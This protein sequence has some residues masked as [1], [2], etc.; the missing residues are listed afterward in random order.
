MKYR[1][2]QG[3]RV[4]ET[5]EYPTKIAVDRIIRTEWVDLVQGL[6]VM[7]R[8]FCY[9]G[10]VPGPKWFLRFLGILGRKS[11]RGY[12]A[13]DALF[14]LMKNGHLE[15]FWK[16]EADKLMHEI[17]LRDGMAKPAAKVVYRSVVAFGASSI[18]P[19]NRVK[20]QTAP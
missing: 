7:K 5:W 1:K 9:E 19:A 20:V 18:D 13:H 16:E 14:N 12:C 15:P 2:V 10:S 4:E 11:K 8:G 17:H 3:F 6:L